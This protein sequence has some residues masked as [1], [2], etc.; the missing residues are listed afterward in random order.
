MRKS[1]LFTKVHRGSV[2]G[3]VVTDSGRFTEKM[4]KWFPKEDKVADAEWE[5]LDHKH[6]GN[7]L[8]MLQQLKGMYIKYGQIGAG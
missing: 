5:R 3:G 8:Q 6:S 7:I 2:E 4:L 1:F